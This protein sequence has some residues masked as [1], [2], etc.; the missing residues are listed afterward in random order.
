MVILLWVSTIFGFLLG[1]TLLVAAVIMKNSRFYLYTLLAILLV[2]AAQFIGLKVWT[3]VLILAVVMEAL[4]IYH[5][6]RFLRAYPISS[7]NE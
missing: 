1:G 5:L 3:A 4:G 7:E 2:L 6:V